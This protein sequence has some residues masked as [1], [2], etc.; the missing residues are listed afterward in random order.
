[1][2]QERYIGI[3]HWASFPEETF[4]QKHQKV[5]VRRMNEL[6][7][8]PLLNLGRLSGQGAGASLSLPLPR[9]GAEVQ[10]AAGLEQLIAAANIEQLDLGW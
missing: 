5:L 8:Q 7:R 9:R 1:M 4:I 3:N 6:R 2:H 10:L